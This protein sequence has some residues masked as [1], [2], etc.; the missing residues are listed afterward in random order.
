MTMPEPDQ[1]QN[2]QG[3]TVEGEWGGDHSSQTKEHKVQRL[4]PDHVQDPYL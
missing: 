1:D 4:A 3:W 2:D